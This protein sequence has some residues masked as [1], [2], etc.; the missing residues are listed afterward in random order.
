MCQV[1]RNVVDESM[2]EASGVGLFVSWAG[3]SVRQPEQALS[4]CAYMEI[5]NDH[6]SGI[7]T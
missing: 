3:K 1:L 5:F 6:P 7:A 2:A 4:F